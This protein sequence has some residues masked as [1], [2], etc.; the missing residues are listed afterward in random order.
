[1]ATGS[2]D[3]AAAMAHPQ[4]VTSVSRRYKATLVAFAIVA[5][6]SAA[7]HD[8]SIYLPIETSSATKAGKI[9]A[10]ASFLSQPPAQ[11]SVGDDPPGREQQERERKPRKQSTH[12]GHVHFVEPGSRLHDLVQKWEESNITVSQ[13]AID[14]NEIVSTDEYI[15]HKPSEGILFMKTH[16]TGNS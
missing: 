4:R 5:L 2:A 11:D 6:C 16:K 12:D 9:K 7:W 10:E 15:N 1:M 3:A 13:A 8:V 14:L